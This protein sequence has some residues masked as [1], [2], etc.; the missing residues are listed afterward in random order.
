MELCVSCKGCK[1]ECPTGVDM[2][3]MKIEFLHHWRRHH[4]LTLK[5]RL[6][7]YLPRY[8]PWAARLAPVINLLQGLAKPLLGFAAQ[9]SLP[10]WR[11]DP[12]AAPPAQ[13][14][15]GGREVVLFVDTFNT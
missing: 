4:G 2:A 7:A 5:E 3:K 15:A 14:A 1:R 6:I 9:R 12:F 11:S 8:A 13:P 10:A